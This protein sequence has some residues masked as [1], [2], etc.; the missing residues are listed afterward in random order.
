MKLERVTGEQLKMRVFP[1]THEDAAISW[2]YYLPQGTIDTW[3][4]MKT[5][6]LEKYFPA[7]RASTL[8]KDISNAEQ[9]DDETMYEYWERFK[10]LCGTCPYHG[11]EDQDLVMYFCG[12]LSKDD[13]RVVNA[14]SGG[15]ILNTNP[16]GAL[17]LIIELTEA[18]R[19]FD[20]K[21]S[22]HEVN[23]IG[24]INNLEE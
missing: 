22:W 12:G 6:F 18:S 15:S 19:D 5:T 7:S 20:R 16:A 8:K 11:H 10:K 13:A 3:L 9:L 23:A 17:T 1:L 2:L 24:S 21:P 4:K 14:A